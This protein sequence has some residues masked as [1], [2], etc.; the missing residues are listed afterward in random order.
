MAHSL[1]SSS[2]AKFSG[3]P[4]L[5]EQLKQHKLGKH[6]PKASQMIVNTTC[7]ATVDVAA[8]CMTSHKPRTRFQL[9]QEV[10]LIDYKILGCSNE[11]TRKP[12]SEK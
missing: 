4:L 2:K 10:H 7:A 11:P 8:V 1:R 12:P 5:Q 6:G 3:W 9:Y